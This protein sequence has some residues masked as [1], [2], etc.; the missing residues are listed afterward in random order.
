[1]HDFG[2]LHGYLSRFWIPNKQAA[3]ETVDG[4][5]VLAIWNLEMFVSKETCPDYPVVPVTTFEPQKRK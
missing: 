2:R 5:P 1:M 4:V 3:K